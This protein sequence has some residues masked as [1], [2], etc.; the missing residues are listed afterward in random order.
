MNSDETA[1]ILER[2]AFL[3]EV[4]GE[5]PFKIRAYSTAARAVSRLGDQ[6]ATM[7]AEGTLEK[8]EGIGPAIAAKIV[9]LEEEG[10][11]PYYEELAEEFPP[12]IFDLLELPGLGPKKIAAMYNAL[13]I[14]SIA[15]LE[16]ACRDGHLA[17][18]EGFGEKTSEK[19]LEGIRQREKNARLF[20]PYEVINES[21][22]VLDSLRA[23]PSTLQSS[24][25]GALRRG[26]E[27]VDSL[28]FV[29]AS[30]DPAQTLDYFEQLPVIAEKI[31]RSEEKSV[32]RLLSGIPAT[33]FGT[34]NAAY[35]FEL[36]CRTGSREHVARLK[37]LAENQGWHLTPSGFEPHENAAFGEC[38][39]PP[40]Q[41]ND[42]PELYS[43]L[44]LQFV[45]PELREDTGE[46]AAA[47]D[48]ALPKLVDLPNLRGTFHCHT[49][50]SDGKHSLEQM[51][52]MAIQLGLQYL[53][54]SDHSRSSVQANGLSEERLLAQIAQIRQF[55]ASQEGFRLF[56]GT[57]CDI[58]KHGGL[59]FPEEILGQLD[60]VVASIHSSFGL[61]KI[62]MTER[63]LRAIHS[64]YVNM[65]GHPTG[66]LLTGREPY[67]V[68]LPVII[69][70]AAETDTVI[71]LNCSPQRM[72]LDWR[73][74][75]LARE[76]GVRCS[77]NTDAHRMEGLGVLWQGVR[78]AR[79][80]W[81]RR[82]D[83]INC[84]PLGEIEM[85]LALKRDQ[86]GIPEN[87]GPLPSGESL[88]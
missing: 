11:L 1:E 45:V 61:G 3:L 43:A 46:L 50:A 30:S 13:G 78:V 83:V 7:I 66:R 77:I 85:Q 39:P 71:E 63:L 75:R 51:A 33:L 34:T 38:E 21:D 65:I 79:K 49:T 16:A 6:L 17:T 40:V 69:E 68:D 22:Y 81:L 84:L 15:E 32:V 76:R 37:T 12:G 31:E 2:I 23:L 26:C 9:Q 20:L 55:N 80:G 82:E 57:E 54:I 72:E 10:R 18:L 53:G 36:L 59:D 14:S 64:P 25:A 19:I 62:Q 70:A 56:A 48:D 87:G 88:V 58:L 8:A 24:A 41:I 74:W 42:E 29:F 5:N 28:K 73:W 47:A 35:A 4:R 44:N 60:F 86:F 67:P 52:E 27:V